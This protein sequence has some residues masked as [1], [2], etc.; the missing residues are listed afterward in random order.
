MARRGPDKE[1]ERYRSL[2]DTPSEFKEGFGWT[3]VAGIFFCGLVMLPGSIYLGLM[4]GGGLGAAATWVT[5]ILF[6]KIARRA[7][8]AMNKQQLVILLH[9]AGIMIAANAM[10]PGGPFGHFVYRAFLVSSEAVRDA[11]MANSFPEW[12]V[13]NPASDAIVE[14]NFFHSDWLVPIGL[15]AFMI[16]IGSIRRYTLGYFFF[17]ITSDIE[18]LPFPMA[19][20]RAQGAMALAEMDEKPADSQDTGKGPDDEKDKDVALDE[21]GEKPR[22]TFSKWRLFSLGVVIGISFGALQVGVPAVTGLFLDKPVYLIP[23]PFLDT[24]TWTESILPATPTGVAIDLGIIA[25]GFVLPFWAIMGTF[26]AIVLTLVLNPLLH[27]TGVLSHWQPGMNT[28]NTAFAN[29]IDFWLSFGIGAGL[30]IATVSIYSTVRDVVKKA[31]DL[32]QNRSTDK[33]EDVWAT[34]KGRGDYPLWIALLIYAGTSVAIVWLCYQLVPQ[35]SVW[36]LLAFCFLYNPFISYVNARLL[37]I[38]GQ[39]VNIPFI[40]ETA[41]ILSGAKGVD[42][43]LAP[44]PIENFG[45][46]AQAYRVN[47]LTGVSFWSL[48]KVDFVA[49]PIL[50]VLSGLFWAFIWRSGQIPSDAYPYAQVNWEYASKNNVLLYSS[51]FVAPGED[52]DSKSLA[53]SEFMKAIHPKTIGAGFGFTV[54]GFAVLSIFGLPVMLIYGFIRG[55]GQFPHIMVLEIVGAMLG[56]FYFRK[57]F[58]ASNFLRMAPTALAG[59]F[60]GVGLISMATIAMNL[61]K[62]AVSGAPF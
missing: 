27:H 16:V 8:K 48:I 40:R 24:T 53:D 23:Q 14:R 13:P 20:I 58:G 31:R 5:V 42:I 36:F 52:P 7:M 15:T 50:F 30:G 38:A 55:L 2:L 6:A 12:F 45:G 25:I 33:R 22:K 19:P 3:T 29:N 26:F 10:F 43:W 54:I 39:Q 35:I 28:I 41:F 57:K 44:I 32:R 59:Y 61:I 9:A 18:N 34:K 17:R 4:T 47:E 37:G 56:R 49:I 60:T 51:T 62:N 11:G 46:M 21:D 1:I